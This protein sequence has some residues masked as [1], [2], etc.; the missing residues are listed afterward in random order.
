[1]ASTITGKIQKT[2]KR[3]QHRDKDLERNGYKVLHIW[4]SEY[5]QNPQAT[6][7]KCITF[8]NS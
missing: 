3:E 5:K 6:I 7:N 4:E 2:K 1:M 8:L